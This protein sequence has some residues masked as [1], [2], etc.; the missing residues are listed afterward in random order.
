MDFFDAFLNPE[1]IA[2]Y[3]RPMVR[4]VWVTIWISVLVVISGLALG[5]LLAGLR[6]YQKRW[7]SWPIVLFADLMRA[8]PPLVLMLILFFGLPSIGIILNDWFVLYLILTLVLAAFVEEIFWATMTS[9]PR[10]QW[11]AGAATGL[12]FL[13]VLVHVI[14]P[15][16]LRMNIPPLVNRSLTI[17]KMT[18]Y[19]SVIGV[20]EIVSVAGSA[21]AFSG[22]ATPLTMAALAY[23][24]IF[25]PAMLLSRYIEDRF[26]YEH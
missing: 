24:I 4:A 20:K 5:A 26:H 3:L 14:F 6:A 19:G 7:L 9:L 10:G 8:L 17:S 23:L 22:S 13:Q 12:S 25:F 2:T 16:A 18:A 21:Q 11:E 1:I 15:Q